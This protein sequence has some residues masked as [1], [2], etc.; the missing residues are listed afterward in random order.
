MKFI[1]NK[2]CTGKTRALIK[3]SLDEDIPIFAMY[4]GKAE[5]L[6]E[7]SISYFDKVVRVVTPQ[8][9]A[10]G[11]KGAILVDDMDKTFHTL[12]ATH[13]NSY[14]FCVAGATLTED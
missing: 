2:N 7:K 1:I 3:Q 12:L 8:D 14:D 5:S 6:R 10:N 13:V 11:Y 9:F 4:Q